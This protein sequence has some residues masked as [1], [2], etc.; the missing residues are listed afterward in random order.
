MLGLVIGLASPALAYGAI[1]HYSCVA[2][3]Y[4]G[5]AKLVGYGTQ[6]RLYIYPK[7]SPQDGDWVNSIYG[8][9][10]YGA[11]YEAG[12]YW[13]PNVSLTPW[14]FT[15][16]YDGV[17]HSER[18]KTTSLAPGTRHYFRVANNAVDF[19]YRAYVD[20]QLIDTWYNTTIR[21]SYPC[22]GSERYDTRDYNKGQLQYVSYLHTV[23]PETWVYWADAAINNDTDPNYHPYF[24]YLD[25]SDHYIYV[26]DHQN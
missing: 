16:L 22:V 25:R 3:G 4:Y 5:S 14:V 10:M 9:N 19:T 20:G 13:A 18:L 1:V 11:F 7:Q 6:A 15:H 21:S 26:D 17:T 2:Q 24:N 23:S 8:G 12:W